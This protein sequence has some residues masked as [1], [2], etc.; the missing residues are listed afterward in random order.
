MVILVDTGAAHEEWPSRTY[1]HPITPL[2]TSTPAENALAKHGVGPDDVDIIINTHLHWDHCFNN[3]LFPKAAVYVQET[4]VRFAACPV[5]TQRNYYET[6]Q[7]GMT[8]RWTESAARFRTVDGD[9]SLCSG[10]DLLF[11]PG[12]TDGFQGV[13]VNTTAGPCLI[14]SDCLPLYENWPGQ[15]AEFH[16]TGIHTDL[17]ALFSS[18]QRIAQLNA[19]FFPGHDIGV[20]KIAKYPIEGE[21]GNAK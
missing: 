17:S 12:H 4:E 6:F 16:A 1:H 18:Y 11:L 15:G 14:A 20:L 9:F 10:I 7:L 2:R 5:P 13:L 8:P 3:S 21:Q 19:A